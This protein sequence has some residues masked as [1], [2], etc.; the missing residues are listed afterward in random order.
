MRKGESAPS[1]KATPVEKPT[2][3]MTSA[4]EMRK[5]DQSRQT[6]GQIARSNRSVEPLMQRSMRSND[7]P[8]LH[9]EDPAAALNISDDKWNSMVKENLQKFEEDKVKAIQAKRDKNRKV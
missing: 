3:L 5:T 9:Y 2:K 1:A 4:T 7:Q 8:M 6:S